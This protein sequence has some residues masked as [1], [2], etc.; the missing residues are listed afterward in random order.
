M[1]PRPFRQSAER[2][3]EWLGRSPS[4]RAVHGLRGQDR[5]ARRIVRKRETRRY[6][7]RR[8]RPANLKLV[9]SLHRAVRR[10]I[11]RPGVPRPAAEQR[12]LAYDFQEGELRRGR[13]SG[14]RPPLR[15]LIRWS[16]N[17]LDNRRAAMRHPYVELASWRCFDPLPEADR[18]GPILHRVE[19]HFRPGHRGPP[20]DLADNGV[21]RGDDDR[22]FGLRR[23]AGW[24]C[25]GHRDRGRE[26]A[27]QVPHVSPF[28]LPTPCAGRAGAPVPC[29]AWRTI[30]PDKC[31]KRRS[32][33]RWNRS[34]TTTSGKSSQITWVFW[35]RKI[36]A[37]M[38]E[39][40]MTAVVTL[41][42]VFICASDGSSSPR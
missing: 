11:E 4:N 38:T 3:H 27:K 40:K 13:P 6:A 12:R 37:T 42:I 31:L 32:T 39:T 29:E 35:T 7:G 33:G 18:P 30:L 10:R 8:R 41:W 5:G 21:D 17:R 19:Q 2:G 36:P 16:R 24:I 23:R 20:V 25:Q 26:S 1:P 22:R 15:G 9:E 34:P 14:K 28:P